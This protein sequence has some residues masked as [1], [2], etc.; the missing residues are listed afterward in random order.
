MN[1]EATRSTNF[2]E[3]ESAASFVKAALGELRPTVAVVLGSGLGGVSEIV[4]PSVTLDF[5]QIPGF[6]GSTVEGH[7]GRVL[8]GSF[9]GLDVLFQSGRFHLY[10]GCSGYSVLLPVRTWA[11]LGIENLIVTNAAG[12]IRSDWPVPSLMLVADYVN[13]TFRSPLSGAKALNEERFPDAAHVMDTFLVESALASATEA[14]IAIYEG[15]Y[16]AVLGPQYETPA[17][18]RMLKKFGADAVGMSTMPEL[19]AAS[20]LGLKAVALSALT[21]KASGVGTAKL[22]HDEVLAASSN[23]EGEMKTIIQG[24]LASIRTTKRNV[25]R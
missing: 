25:I 11:K 5:D 23:V 18:I 2:E 19:L 13:W 8:V 17:E 1:E 24:I 14:Q 10:E 21:N 15:T 20:A 12:C 7:T 4:S 6:S 22:N 9:E 16:A 3:V